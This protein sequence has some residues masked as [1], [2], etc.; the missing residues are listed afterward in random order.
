MKHLFCLVALTVLLTSCTDP[1]VPAIRNDT[2]L[3]LIEGDIVDRAGRSSVSVQRW[4]PDDNTY[5]IFPQRDLGVTSIAGDGEEITW[6]EREDA[7]VYLPPDGFVGRVGVAYRIRVVTPGGGVFESRPE[8]IPPPATFSGL[9]AEFEQESYFSAGLNRFV[10]A[11]R[12][13]LN[14][15]DP[16]GEANYY[17]ANYRR[18]ETIRKCASCSRARYR[19]GECIPDGRNLGV[20]DYL[21]DTVCYQ[22][23]EGDDGNIFDDAFADG[24]TIPR[25]EVA[26]VDYARQTGGF[27][28][29]ASLQSLTKGRYDYLDLIRTLSEEGGGLNATIPAPLV[30][31]LETISSEREGEPTILLGYFG[32]ASEYSDRIFFRNEDVDG[33]P[34]PSNE[35][36][37]EEPGVPNCDQF[38]LGCPPLAP[39]DGPNRTNIQPEGWGG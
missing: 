1:L 14:I 39:C 24:G 29:E 13:Y 33:Q 7:G 32:A 27:L 10:P 5:R 16:A 19:N 2:E 18:W 17:R 15:E 20:W 6:A 28:F 3:F 34:L 25:F 36:I 21:C 11:F 12:F 8:T 37:R 9:T 35:D 38:P 31:N 30:G 23:Y 22:M 4:V 26:R